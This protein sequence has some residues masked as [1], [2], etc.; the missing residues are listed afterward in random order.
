MLTRGV[1]P[2][3][4]VQADASA[5]TGGLAALVPVINGVGGNIASI[6]ASRT[7]TALHNLSASASAAAPEDTGDSGDV[8]K[9]GSVPAGPA[10]SASAR[11]NA[12]TTAAAEMSPV[13]AKSARNGA[14]G[15]QQRSAGKAPSANLQALPAAAA[16]TAT[17]DSALSAPLSSSPSSARARRDPSL[18]LRPGREGTW[19]PF[20]TLAVL[21]LLT[22]GAFLLVVRLVTDLSR[23]GGDG[24]S[25]LS[26]AFCAAF[27]CASLVQVAVLVRAARSLAEYWWRVGLDPDNHCVSEQVLSDAVPV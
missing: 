21:N 27:L 20:P 5:L 4:I 6:Y 17:L 26:A 11:S 25:R 9:S 8:S 18:L 1:W 22:E 2:E 7:S 23:R 19:Q 16:A 14:S 10:S 3:F 12:A 24:G 13:P 15:L